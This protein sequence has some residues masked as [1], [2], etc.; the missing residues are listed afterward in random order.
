MSQQQHVSKRA[1]TIPSL[2]TAGIVGVSSEG[3]A[4]FSESTENRPK[5]PENIKKF[6][7][8]YQRA[9][10]QKFLHTGKT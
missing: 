7:M 3:A 1:D 5:T 4:I 9:P 6:R 8:S 2:Q 10:G